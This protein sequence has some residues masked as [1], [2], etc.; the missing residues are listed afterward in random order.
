MDVRTLLIAGRIIEVAQLRSARAGA[1]TLVF[2]HEGLGSIAL[3]RDFPRRVAQRTGCPALVYSR[4]GNGFSEVLEGPRGVE[5]MHD[6]ALILLPALLE[7]LGI[8]R[9]ILFGHSDGASI[10]CIY[11]SAHPENIAGMILE[12]PHVIVEELSIR[13]IAAIGARY[14]E[15]S[16]REK[17]RPYHR[18]V[19]ATFYGWNRIWLDPAFRAW[20]LVER[21]PHMDAPALAIQGCDDEYGTVEQ[22]RILA[23]RSG[24]TV[25]RLVLARCGHAPHRDRSALVEET[26]V[27]WLRERL[28]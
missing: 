12:A 11:A 27:A 10:A 20:S 3:W 25:D 28:A 7:E 9:P 26:A 5:Y 6:E 24:G 23:E 2:L 15:G 21:L 1:P 17:L 13:S 19:D 18:D 14:R 8:V 22:I 4:F 16:L